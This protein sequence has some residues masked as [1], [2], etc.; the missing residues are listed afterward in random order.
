MYY[1]AVIFL[2]ELCNDLS[3]FDRRQLDSILPR[4]KEDVN[5][6]DSANRN[7]KKVSH[8]MGIW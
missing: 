4:I 5:I 7:V 3:E 2:V 1:H 8:S 6:L